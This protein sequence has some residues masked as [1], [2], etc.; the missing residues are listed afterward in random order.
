MSGPSKNPYASPQP[1]QAVPPLNW[2]PP[3]GIEAAPCPN[4]GNTQA[5]KIEFT[6]WGGLIGP[7]MFNHVKCLSCGQTYNA[8]TGRSN[9]TAIILYQVVILTVIA[10]LFL[11]F[12]FL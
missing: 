7:R 6:W 12:R 1:P 2:P 9:F 4:C 5:K 3:T 8:K 10:L 11:A